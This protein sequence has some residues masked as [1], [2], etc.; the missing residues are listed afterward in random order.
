M[1]CSANRSAS[2]PPML[3]QPIMATYKVEDIS[4]VCSI[5]WFLAGT[6]LLD[7]HC[8]RVP[9]AKSSGWNKFSLSSYGE[10]GKFQH[11]QAFIWGNDSHSLARNIEPWLIILMSLTVTCMKITRIPVIL[12]LHSFLTIPTIPV[13]EN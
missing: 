13:I 8:F 11:H 10:I 5:A 4:M 2:P 7:P 3:P 1:P 9:K 12:K 6:Y